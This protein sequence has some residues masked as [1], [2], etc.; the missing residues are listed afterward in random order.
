MSLPMVCLLGHQITIAPSPRVQWWTLGRHRASSTFFYCLCSAASCPLGSPSV[1]HRPRTWG[2]PRCCGATEPG[3]HHLAVVEGVHVAA[4]WARTP[5]RSLR[6][7]VSASAAA[8]CHMVMWKERGR[9]LCAHRSV[10][11]DFAA[12]ASPPLCAACV[13]QTACPPP[14]AAAEETHRSTTEGHGTRLSQSECRGR[15]VQHRSLGPVTPAIS[16]KLQ[17]RSAQTQNAVC[18]FRQEW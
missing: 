17:H 10:S 1:P 8:C 12:L 16:S 4:R 7:A 14:L 13:P 3:S 2:T 11:Q 18:L 6:A 15:R 9:G 5:D